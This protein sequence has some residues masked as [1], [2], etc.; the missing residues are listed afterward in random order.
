MKNVNVL[1]GLVKGLLLAGES[2]IAEKILLNA[3]MNEAEKCT[4]EL[5]KCK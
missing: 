3:Y 1:K 2:T 5:K 4:D